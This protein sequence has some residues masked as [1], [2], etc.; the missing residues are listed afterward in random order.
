MSLIKLSAIEVAAAIES[1]DTTCA[2]V[3]RALLDRI[4]ERE[5]DVG[6]WEFIDPDAALAAAK[7][8]DNIPSKGMIHGVPIGV[9]DIIDTRDMP[10]THGSPIHKDN[11]PCSDAP[12]VSLVRGAGGLVLGKTVTSEFAAQRAGKTKNPHNPAHSPAG[13]SSGSAAAVT[14]FMVPVAFGTQTGGSIVRPG[15]FCGCIGY[16]P[17]YGDYNPL[18]VHDNTRSVDTLGMLSRTMS[19]QVLMRSVLTHTPYRPIQTTP[20]SDLRIGVCR[21]PNWRLADETTKECLLHAAQTLEASGA[22]IEDFDL[23][24]GFDDAIEGFD[25]VSGYEISR[26]LAYEWFNYPDLL[27]DNM[28]NNRVPNGLKITPTEYQAGLA[29]LVDYR[30]R[31]AASLEN[32]DVLITPSAIGEAPPD[33]TTIGEPPFNRIWTGLYGPAINLPLFTGPQGLPIGLQVIG[34]VGQDDRFLDA[35]DGIYQV[36][37][38]I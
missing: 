31:Y 25:L 14:D 37:S 32:W 30:R 3:T 38:R 18:G 17:T 19:D 6:A 9:K 2:A 23:P 1:G 12:C 13:S 5:P 11:R 20:V 15:A 33:L 35:A 4:E 29:I 26:T 21:T 22:K 24:D 34:H 28:R 16:K 7:V 10:T 8:L 27:S 36:L